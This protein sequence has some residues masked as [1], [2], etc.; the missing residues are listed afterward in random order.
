MGFHQLRVE[1][2]DSLRARAHHYCAKA[3][4]PVPSP[5]LAEH[6]FSGDQPEDGV[7][8]LLIRALLR[9]DDRFHEMRR[10][11]W[12]V[13]DARY[14]GVPLERAR[15]AVVDLEATGSNPR[16]DHIIEVGVVV[17][18]GLEVTARYSSLVNPLVRIPSWI[19]R[20][21]GIDEAKLQD[22]PRFHQI[23]PE[24]MQHLEGAVFVAHNV[25]FDYPF[26]RSH[27]RAVDHEPPPWPQLCTLRLAR[28]TLRGLPSYRLDAIAKHC[29]IDLDRHHR[30]I[31]DAE[32]TAGVL[33]RMV[34]QLRESGVETVG[35][36][37][38]ASNGR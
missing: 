36:L 15:F 23:A 38:S 14:H 31:A 28:K 10:G 19:R 18:E 20:L 33:L 35:E 21:T 11:T 29:G 25:D 6:L 12:E 4:R 30:A 16:S 7:S 2:L 1:D 32:A 22:A 27:L 24:I 13:V 5:E 9:R 8:P 26:L 3:N 37:L 17:V 34:S